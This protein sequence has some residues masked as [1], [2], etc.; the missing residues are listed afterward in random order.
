MSS[1]RLGEYTDE[2]IIHI[3]TIIEAEFI[4]L[5]SLLLYLFKFSVIKKLKEK[6][7]KPAVISLLKNFH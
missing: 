7:K 5:P 4:L 3:M 1:R 2:M 6:K